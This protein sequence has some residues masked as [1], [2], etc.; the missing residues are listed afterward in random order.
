[1]ASLRCLSLTVTIAALVL[2]TPAMALQA[3][4]DHS[5]SDVT[6]QAQGLRITEQQEIV[7]DSLSYID[8]DGLGA[9]GTIGSIT[10][11]NIRQFTPN[12]R[13][14]IRDFEVKQT[15]KGQALV[16]TSRE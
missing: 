13:P 14:T 2:S 1:M 12:N 16:M 6:G 5:L 3:M 8:D 11:S 15:A 4:D 9:D 10:L 7:I